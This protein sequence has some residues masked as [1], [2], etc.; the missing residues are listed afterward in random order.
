MNYT[1]AG[2][3]ARG[4]IIIFALAGGVTLLGGCSIF[5]RSAADPRPETWATR[6][7]AN[8]GLENLWRVNSSLY[9]S[10]QPTKG[11]FAFLGTR[12]SL[13]SG[14]RPIKTIVSLRSSEDDTLSVPTASA[15][16]FVQIRFRTLDAEDEDVV[17]FLRI[18]TT[19]ALQPVLVHCR[20]GADRTGTMVAI[21][22]IA[23]DG[24]TKAQAI[25]EMVRGGFGFNPLWVNLTDYIKKLDVDAIK[26]KVKKQGAWQ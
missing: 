22:R 4:K 10:K 7:E 19:P 5:T 12:P 14:D 3:A 18:A 16:R 24:W 1:Y 9:R 6:V 11:G 13:V 17:K 25:D 21:Y 15:L 23:Y 8:P 26:D 2:Q 20:R